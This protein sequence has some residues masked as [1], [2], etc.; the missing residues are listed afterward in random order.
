MGFNLA[1]KGLR[2]IIVLPSYP[3]MLCRFRMWRHY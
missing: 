3:T 1:F 2:F